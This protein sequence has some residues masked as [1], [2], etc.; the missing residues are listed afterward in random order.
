MRM[1]RIRNVYRVR[2]ECFVCGVIYWLGEV[3]YLAYDVG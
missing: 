3:A 1:L 2:R